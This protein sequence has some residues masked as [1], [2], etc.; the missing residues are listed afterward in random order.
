MA[1]SGWHLFI[2]C[3]FCFLSRLNHSPLQRYKAK[4]ELSRHTPLQG[5]VCGLF[6]V[7]FFALYDPLA[8]RDGKTQKRQK[9]DDEK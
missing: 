3:F 9:K 6:H 4:K 1:I 5:I 2:I 7:S 8:Q